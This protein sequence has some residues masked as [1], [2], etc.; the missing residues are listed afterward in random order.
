MW[1]AGKLQRKNA[2]TPA[3]FL[4]NKNAND[5]EKKPQPTL[6]PWENGGRRLI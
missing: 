4:K 3:L 2:P 6:I 1:M 5:P